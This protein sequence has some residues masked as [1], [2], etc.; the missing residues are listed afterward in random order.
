MLR[1][2]ILKR[3]MKLLLNIVRLRGLVTRD[4][5]TK[6]PLQLRFLVHPHAQ[7]MS[8]RQLMHAAQDGALCLERVPEFQKLTNRAAIERRPKARKRQQGLEFRCEHNIAARRNPVVERL[9]AHRI[10]KQKQGTLCRAPNGECE[11]AAD[12]AYAF[13]TPRRECIQKNLGVRLRT[14]SITFRLEVTPQFT[15]IVDLAIE[16]Q[17]IAV[18]GVHH[19]LMATRSETNDAQAVVAKCQA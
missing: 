19:W 18:F 6:V 17:Y 15:E 7:E 12:I 9:D 13:A 4:F 14:E 5:R 3:R 1:R 2:Y 8:R 16:D 10:P 11:H